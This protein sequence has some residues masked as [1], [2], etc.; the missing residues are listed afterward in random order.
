MPTKNNLWGYDLDKEFH[1][2]L[3]LCP[4]TT[5]LGNYL[6][7]YCDALKIYRK[8]Q[9]NNFDKDINENPKV[10]NMFQNLKEIIQ[11][12]GFPYNY[13]NQNTT[14]TSQVLSHKKQNIIYVE[15]LI[16]AH[17]CFVHEC[18]MEGIANILSRA[19]SLNSILCSA[20]SWNLIVR[21]LTG[22]GRYRE[23]YFCF[24]TLMK[25]DQFESL[26]GQFDEDKTNGLRHAIIW[27][28]KEYCP[29]NK[30]YLKLTALHF[31]MFKELAELW[32]EEMNSTIAK[33]LSENQKHEEINQSNYTNDNNGN[34]DKATTTT[35]TK[36]SMMS[37]SLTVLNQLNEVLNMSIQTV[38]NYLCDNKLRLAKK[39]ASNA[40]LIALQIDLINK[41]IISSSQYCICILNI[42]SQ[43]EFR[44]LINKELR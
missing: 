26:L 3:E 39:S 12:Y 18:S 21:M 6:L 10:I 22:I 43:D 44:E 33:I 15:L 2:L 8:Y 11:I 32:E 36:T 42:R 35:I 5:V 37:C 16:K 31:L 24:D 1:L 28:I 14:T 7:Y 41:A 20:K 4:N 40:E 30:E 9:D 19:K 34:N 38:E 13:Q 17:E 23:M 29:Q 25:N 27:Y